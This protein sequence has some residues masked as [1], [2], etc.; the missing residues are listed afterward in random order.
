MSGACNIYLKYENGDDINKIVEMFNN[1]YTF[2]GSE[3]YGVEYD[4]EDDG[5]NIEKF[6]DI[7]NK[8]E[9]TVIGLGWHSSMEWFA[10]FNIDKGEVKRHIVHGE[11]NWL[12]CNGMKEEW[13]DNIIFSNSEKELGFIKEDFENQQLSREEY[14]K[15]KKIYENRELCVNEFFPFITVYDLAEEIGKK[16][17]LPDWL[18]ESE[19]LEEFNKNRANMIIAKNQKKWWRFW[20]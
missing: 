19:E 3:F 5:I 6:I 4:F 20:K 16:Y 18:K 17:E 11:A 2:E 15:L 1:A 9:T 14:E 7:S 8:L 10:Y 13:E 12:V